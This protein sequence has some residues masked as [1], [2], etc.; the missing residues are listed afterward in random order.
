[1]L[2][3]SDSF[4]GEWMGRKF[5]VKKGQLIDEEH[6]LAKAYEVL[7]EPV[8][9]D[10]PTWD[11]EQATQAPGETRQ[12]VPANTDDLDG[13]SLSNLQYIAAKEKLITSGSKADLIER[14]RA[15]RESEG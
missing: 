14:I 7:F 8:R 9:A 6:P 1:M 13:K 5:F 11:V 2:R 15:H 10:I 3:A 12:V 4:A